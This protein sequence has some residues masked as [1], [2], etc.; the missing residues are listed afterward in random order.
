MATNNYIEIPI[1]HKV[2]VL[3]AKD[4]TKE[5]LVDLKYY[6]EKEQLNFYTHHTI[7]NAK[8]KAN[9]YSES[10]PRCPTVDDDADFVLEETETTIAIEDIKKQLG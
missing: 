10:N 3:L 4:E 1:K 5:L 2:D 9:V 6:L 8:I 7:G